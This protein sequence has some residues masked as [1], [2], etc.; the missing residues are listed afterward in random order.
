MAADKVLEVMRKA[1]KPL[2]TAEIADLAKLDKDEVAK[3][4]KSLKKDG[5]IVSP[6]NCYYAVA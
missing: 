1:G 5:A 3:I 2:K 4:I 6:K